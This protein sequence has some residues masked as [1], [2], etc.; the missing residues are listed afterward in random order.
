MSV[1]RGYHVEALR[2]EFP[3]LSRRMG[4]RPLVYLDNAATTQRPSRVIEAMRS[5]AREHHANVHRG[6]H[7][8]SVEA[9]SLYEEARRE[10]ARFIG[11][12][13][14]REIVFTRNATEAVNLV[15]HTW[16][17][18]FLEPGDVVVLSEM[19]HHSNL[20]PWQLLARRK[21]VRLAFLPFDENGMLDLASLDELWTERVKLVSLVH[22]SNVFGTV[23][24]VEEIVEY[25][26]RRGA[27]VLLDGAQA[28]PHLPISVEALGCDFFAFS[29]HKMYG[30]MGIGVLYAREELLEAM[31]PFLGGG[32][33]IRSVTLET[34]TWNEVPHKFEAGTPNVE[35]AVGLAEAVRFLREVGMEAVAAHEQE[36]TAYALEA[37]KWVPDIT[38]YG[39]GVPHQAGIVS[40]TLKEV[41]PHDIAQ[42]LDREG[43]AVRAGHHCAQPAMRKLGVPATAR[44]SFGLYTTREEIDILVSSLIKVQEFF[45]HA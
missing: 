42:L 39:P 28:V 34:A 7:T 1:A 15:A 13:S 26:H 18:A 37:M 32:E 20:I 40:F 24:P 12:G 44:A 36:L 8:L 14:E 21:G 11:A 43:V 38:L 10:V 27:L 25:A 3:I 31:P 41:H 6:L 45:R 29:G 4:G 35:G 9:T 16:A 23:N 5:Y 17:E 22:V 30:P 33:M 19:E 2:A